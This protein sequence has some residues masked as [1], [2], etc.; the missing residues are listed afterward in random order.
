MATLVYDSWLAEVVGFDCYK[1]ESCNADPRSVMREITRRP[2]FLYA[3]VPLTEVA[4]IKA[5][6]NA[7]YYFVD[8]NV[9]LQHVASAD[10]G[11]VNEAVVVEPAAAADHAAAQDIAG[12]SFTYSRF[13][14]DPNFPGALA[15]RVKREWVRSY[16]VGRRGEQLVVARLGGRVAGFLAVLAAEVE[17]RSAAI[18]DLIAVDRSA[19]K[20]GVG[21]ALVHYFVTCWGE[22]VQALRVGTQ[23]ANLPSLALYRRCGF[24]IIEA[25]QVLHAHLRDGGVL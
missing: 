2:A 1:T 8:T 19:R 7:G 11:C 25:R 9:T 17:G 15:D 21:A 4:T 3:K 22:R 20:A 23:L 12:N 5:L 14:L 18:I 24:A 10:G 16:C 6:T 13:H